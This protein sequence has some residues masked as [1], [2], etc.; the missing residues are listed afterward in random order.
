M[1]EATTLLSKVLQFVSRDVLALSAF[2]L[3][4]V[5]TVDILWNTDSR[6]GL[7]YWCVKQ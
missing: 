6:D 4:I 1:R 7:V 5:Y 2:F 3:K